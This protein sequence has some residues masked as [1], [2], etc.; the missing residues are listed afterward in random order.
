MTSAMTPEEVEAFARQV[1]DGSRRAL[2]R[3]I[4]WLENDDDRAAACMELLYPHTGG[5]YVLGIT[6]SPGAGK[7]SLT[8]KLID[9]FRR[10]E[11]RVGIIAVD[12]T[13]PFTGG[14]LL[15]DR[16]RMTQH[17]LD[18]G[19]FIRSMATRGFLGGL[20]QASEGVIK[21]MDA[22][23]LQVILIE[24]VGVG[25]DEVDV[26]R[27]ADTVCLVLVP[28][29][30]DVIQSMKAGVMEIADIYA[31]NKSDL[32]G[33]D[34]LFTEVKARVSQDGQLSAQPWTPPVVK[35]VGTDKMSIIELTDA[36]ETH[37]RFLAESGALTARRRQ[38][39]RQETLEMIHQELFRQLRQHLAQSRRIDAIVDQI[40][41]N[42]QN[43]YRVM[44]QVIAEFLGH[45]RSDR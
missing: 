42:K 40:M 16:V 18:E 17:T 5:A 12:P 28:G 35:T 22:A 13:S 30:G 33:A 25:Q 43:P 38:R 24:T 8:D 1:R 29:F 41:E 2:A 15:G 11:I 20:A 32:P 14:A 34:R 39:V 9:H 23:G 3:L 21:A 10:Q 44:R 4:T 31:V 19:V 36:I 7:S 27:I 6:G 37:R 45:E 26:V